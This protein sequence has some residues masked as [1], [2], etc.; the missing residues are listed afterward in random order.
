[1]HRGRSTTGAEGD[2]AL[3]LKFLFAEFVVLALTTSLTTS[4]RFVRLAKKTARSSVL[5]SL[6]LVMH[7]LSVGEIVTSQLI[8]PV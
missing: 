5:R 8:V 3:G 4:V 2:E 6:A 7:Q 1:M